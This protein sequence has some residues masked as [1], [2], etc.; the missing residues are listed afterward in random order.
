[1]GLQQQSSMLVFLLLT[2]SYQADALDRTLVDGATGSNVVQA[3]IAKVDASPIAFGD[4]H[5]LLRRLAFVETS[6]GANSSY[7]SGGLWGLHQSHLDTVSS[8]PQLEELRIAIRAAFG[9]VWGTVTI[10]DLGKPFF[11]GLVARLY[12]FYLEISGTAVIPL[13]G[14][15]VGQ[16]RFWLTYYHSDVGGVS[17]TEI[18]FVEQVDILEEREGAVVNQAY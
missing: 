5:R 14:D 11:A 3:V 7:S 17:D 10:N 2:L 4:D 6:D 1:M 13:A 12:L 9:I 8:S 16:A 15:I 18:Y